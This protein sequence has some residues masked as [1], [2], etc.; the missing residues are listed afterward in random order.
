MA[1]LAALSEHIF[2]LVNVGYSLNAVER[3]NKIVRMEYYISGNNF[4]VARLAGVIISSL[5][6]WNFVLPPIT[7]ALVVAMQMTPEPSHTAPP[8]LNFL[9][10]LDLFSSWMHD[11]SQQVLEHA[12][13][14]GI[15]FWEKLF[16]SLRVLAELQFCF[17]LTKLSCG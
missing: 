2:G 12:S 16:G 5:L 6:I 11:L 10:F 8:W 13:C 15:F 3:R 17:K 1:T 4:P 7:A 14:V 9:D